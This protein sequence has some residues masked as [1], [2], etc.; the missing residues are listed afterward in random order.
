MTS[1]VPANFR[2]ERLAAAAVAALFALAVFSE[3][4]AAALEDL[5]KAAEDGDLAAAQNAVANGA[6]VNENGCRAQAAPLHRAVWSGK[7]NIVTL[8]VAEGAD[9]NARQM[10]GAAPLHLA[11]VN[12][13]RIPESGPR[14]NNANIVNYLLAQNPNVNAQDISGKTPL[15][16]ALEYRFLIRSAFSALLNSNANVNLA[17][18]RGIAPLHLAVFRELD[19]FYARELLKAGANP[20]QRGPGGRTP[21]HFAAL[22]GNAEKITLL[23]EN[24]ANIRA[25]DDNQQTAMQLASDDSVAELL[26]I[27]PAV[28]SGGSGGGGGGG[29]GM[30][31]AGGVL[32]LGAAWVLTDDAA[33]AF[34]FSPLMFYENKTGAGE[35]SGFGGRMEWRGRRTDLFWQ[36][37]RFGG[38]SSFE[39]GGAARLWKEARLRGKVKARNEQAEWQTGAEWGGAENIRLYAEREG[40]GG[41]G[42]W[43]LGAEFGGGR[44]GWDYGIRADGENFSRQWRG[45]LRAEG[46][47]LF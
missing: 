18:N 1:A 44:E 11:M 10:D 39:F 22:A 7:M 20:N 40:G 28:S 30:V 43:R 31:V 34:S 5:C 38:I 25:Q 33:E 46:E 36:G 8:L 19:S 24:G 45:R 32:V 37:G 13:R 3:A 4:D 15:M 21:L 2:A 14:V 16:L 23:L 17:D 29:L 35:V 47:V 12:T 9:V 6:D 41:V 26:R 42:F 27:P